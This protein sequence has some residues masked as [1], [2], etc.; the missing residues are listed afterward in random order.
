MLVFGERENQRN[1]ENL[2]EQRIY[3]EATIL[4]QNSALDTL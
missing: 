4:V 1:W 3:R 2:S